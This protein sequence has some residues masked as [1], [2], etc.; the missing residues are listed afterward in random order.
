MSAIE[1]S[2]PQAAAL[3]LGEDES[4]YRW[5]VFA[6]VMLTLAGTVNLI[7]GLAAIGG[8]HFFTRH[9]S[10]LIGDLTSLGWIVLCVG[11]VQV[12]AGFGVL[13]RNQLARWVGVTAA[14]LNGVVQLL[15]LPAYPFWSLA[16]FAIDIL[17]M[18]GL[19]VY[20]GRLVR[21]V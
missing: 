11:A 8:S 10:Y 3:R 20:G 1:M 21:P 16:I 4:G 9:A 13:A 6:G 19:L 15:L 5:L 2:G 18:H 17:I 14:A 7:D 12:A